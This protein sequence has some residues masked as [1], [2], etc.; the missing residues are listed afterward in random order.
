MDVR[1]PGVPGPATP[2]GVYSLFT[3]ADF[4]EFI[5]IT[6]SGNYARLARR[7]R[8][9]KE[10]RCILYGFYNGLCMSRRNDSAPC[11]IFTMVC[12]ASQYAMSRQHY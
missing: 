1:R 3:F 9:L 10:A 12:A 11:P 6:S 2:G 7:H 4:R 8:D 5:D